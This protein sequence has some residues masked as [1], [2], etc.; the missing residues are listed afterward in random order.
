M[1]ETEFVLELSIC[2]HLSYIV[3]SRPIKCYSPDSDRGA[4]F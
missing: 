4:V 1:D 3:Y 2:S